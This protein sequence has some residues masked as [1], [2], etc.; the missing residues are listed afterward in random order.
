MYPCGISQA[1]L[2][3]AP[4]SVPAL[5]GAFFLLRQER[6]NPPIDDSLVLLRQECILFFYGHTY[7][8]FLLKFLRILL[9][10]GP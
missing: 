7:T 2:L 8:P 6:F 5:G 4:L 10:L 9:R 3:A 1:A